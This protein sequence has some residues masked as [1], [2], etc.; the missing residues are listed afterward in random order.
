MHHARVWSVVCALLLALPAGAVDAGAGP[1][2]IAF[3]ACADQ[4]LPQP[5]WDAVLGYDPDVFVFAGDNVYGDVSS[6]ELVELRE[7]YAQARS[8][9]GYTDVRTGRAVLAVWDDHDYGA[10]DGGADFPYKAASKQLF[11][12]FWRAPAD[13]PRRRRAG[14]YHAETFG[15]PGR[16]V[17]IVLLDTR[18]FRSPLRPTDARGAPGKERYLPDPDPEKTLLGEAQWAWLEERLREPAELRLIVSSIQVLAQGHGWERWG[19]LPGERAR[20]FELLRTTKAN[21]VVFL[22]GD[23]HFAALYQRHEGAPYSLYEITSSSLNRPRSDTS[24]RDA[25][26]LS[27]GYGAENFGSV[28][29]DWLTGTVTLS[30]R[31]LDGEVVRSVVIALAT[32]AA[33]SR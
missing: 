30:V 21:G 19:N 9:P 7:A 3:G 25:A 20:L 4:R 31:G 6:V 5:I 13:D 10:N 12:D 22:S 15:P 28:D 8:I 27:P 14:I 29:I 16:R 1:S 33:G 24:E 2:R 17:Q 26:L 23:R 11:L 32:L 18:W